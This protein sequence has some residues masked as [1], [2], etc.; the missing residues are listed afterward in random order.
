M[1][2]NPHSVTVD[3]EALL[4]RTAGDA[5]STSARPAV[6]F[7]WEAKLI[8]DFLT[9]EFP[10]GTEGYDFD[11]DTQSTTQQANQSTALPVKAFHYT[12]T[13]GTP[14]VVITVLCPHN[15]LL[16][17]PLTQ[18]LQRQVE[19]LIW[20]RK[21]VECRA[22]IVLF[23]NV[24]NYTR[25]N[26]CIVLW[27]SDKRPGGVVPDNDIRAAFNGRRLSDAL[28]KEDFRDN[29]PA[30]VKASIEA[31]LALLFL[32]AAEAGL[33]IAQDGVYLQSTEPF[34]IQTQRFVIDVN[35]FL[36][37]ALLDATAEP[38]D[39]VKLAFAMDCGV[40]PHASPGAVEQTPS[41]KPYR[42]A[43]GAFHAAFGEQLRPGQT[44]SDL[45]GSLPARHADTSFQVLNCPT[46][47]EAVL[48][49]LSRNQE[50]SKTNWSD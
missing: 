5:P 34:R 45:L 44:P 10:K 1:A 3:L 31:Q 6:T 39:P 15:W 38:T 27:P 8:N 36:V 49:F 26:K 33:H 21:R 24:T 29:L 41:A 7:R 35:G 22:L 30:P 46:P 14:S 23:L 19:R 20:Y 37:R 47:T 25:K 4:G 16:S 40:V 2:P 50:K 17:I 18:P 48:L 12:A 11:E 43:A 32:C 9:R 42:E 28:R 13:S